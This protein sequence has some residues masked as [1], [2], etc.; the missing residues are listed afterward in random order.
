[1]GPLLAARGVQ[2]S[3]PALQSWQAA[4]AGL[5][6]E[7][8]P[9]QD[10]WAAT[11]AAVGALPGGGD[12]AGQ[13]AIGGAADEAAAAAGHA[14]QQLADQA[15]ADTTAAT[16]GSMQ[17]GALARGRVLHDLRSLADSY[18]RGWVCLV[19]FVLATMQ[20]RF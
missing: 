1:M 17:A 11:A 18:Q 15:A 10:Q 4:F 5:G 3:R 12:P 19:E 9:P 14:P 16:Y 13:A 6:P 20:A 2:L 8:P 7:H